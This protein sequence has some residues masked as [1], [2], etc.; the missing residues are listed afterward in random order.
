MPQL[1]T[2]VRLVPA[3]PFAQERVGVN[4]ALVV[5]ASIPLL[6]TLLVRPEPV[7]DPSRLECRRQGVVSTIYHFLSQQKSECSVAHRRSPV[8][9]PKRDRQ[10]FA[11]EPVR[12]RTE[13]AELKQ[14]ARRRASSCG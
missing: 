4:D 1:L 7:F 5:A 2:D 6:E 3:G 12:I 13:Q 11:L 8:D 9:A 10:G 14:K